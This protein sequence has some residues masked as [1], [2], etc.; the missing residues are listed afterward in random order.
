MV[1]I[2]PQA[3][4]KPSTYAGRGVGI[5]ISC[6]LFG[7]NSIVKLGGDAKQ[8]SCYLSLIVGLLL[9]MKAPY[10]SGDATFDYFQATEVDLNHFDSIGTS[11]G[12]N[13]NCDGL[14]R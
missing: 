8:R 13:R 2:A 9:V 1:N 7:F 3:I 14:S 5:E 4:N 10:N 6:L 11:G 12:E